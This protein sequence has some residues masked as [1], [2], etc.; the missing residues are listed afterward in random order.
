MFRI[1][2]V[3]DDPVAQK[4]LLDYLERYERAHEVSFSIDIYEDGA[5]ILSHYRPVYDIVL[6]DIQMEHI[7]GLTAARYVRTLDDQVVLV[8]ITSAPQFA[9]KGYEVDALSYLLKPLPWF[10]FEQELTR[11]IATVRKRKPVSLTLQRGTTLQRVDISDIIYIESIKHRLIVY[12]TKETITLNGTLKD[13]ES[14]LVPHSFFRSNSCYLVNLAHVQGVRD[15]SCY[16]TG[17]TELRISRP[18]KKGFLAALTEFL[19]GVR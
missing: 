19:G 2:I 17:G 5:R 15:Q 7:D 18:R 1:G 14:R 4:L 16:M 10:A 12:T 6:L 11:C 13:M 8:F 3:E 9:I